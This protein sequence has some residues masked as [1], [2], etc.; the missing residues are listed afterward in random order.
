MLDDIRSQLNLAK[1]NHESDMSR[2][3]SRIMVKIDEAQRN[4]EKYVIIDIFLIQIFI[5]QNVFIFLG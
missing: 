5:F 2:L 3:E 4:T 1:T